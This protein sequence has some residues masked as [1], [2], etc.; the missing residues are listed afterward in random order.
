MEDLEGIS[1]SD[2]AS[3]ARGYIEQLTEIGQILIRA[4]VLTH[5]DIDRDGVR[6]AVRNAYERP[7]W[8]PRER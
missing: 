1:H 2:L 8:Y 7:T 6:F 5:A 4:K 3:L